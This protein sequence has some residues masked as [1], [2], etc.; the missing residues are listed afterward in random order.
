MTKAEKRQEL[1]NLYGWTYCLENG[2]P[3][4]VARDGFK[5]DKETVMR[6]NDIDFNDLLDAHY[7]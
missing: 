6:A 1:L 5:V 7:E 3:C 2:K 4:C